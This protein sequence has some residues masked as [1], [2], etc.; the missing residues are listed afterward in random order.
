MTKTVHPTWQQLSDNLDFYSLRDTNIW[1][2]I[3]TS[4]HRYD[5]PDSAQ[6]PRKINA[7]KYNETKT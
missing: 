2:D 4:R 1:F 6:T 5:W 7:L 3:S